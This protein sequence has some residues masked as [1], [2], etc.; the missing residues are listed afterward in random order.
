MK[1]LTFSI[2]SALLTAMSTTM[3]TSVVASVNMAAYQNNPDNSTATAT[4][5]PTQYDGQ[6]LPT[7]FATN[8]NAQLV[9]VS[10]SDNTNSQTSST[11]AQTAGQPDNMNTPAGGANQPE[12]TGTAAP[13]ANQ[14]ASTNSPATANQPATSS[15]TANSKA[16]N[17]SGQTKAPSKTAVTK[18]S[19]TDVTK[20]VSRNYERYNYLAPEYVA[21]STEKGIVYLEGEVAL[22]REFD[23]AY[24][25]ATN[26]NGVLDVKPTALEVRESNVSYEDRKINADARVS[27]YENGLVGENDDITAWPIETR[28]VNGVVYVDGTVENEEQ[29]HEVAQVLYKTEGVE[30]VRMHPELVKPY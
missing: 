21:V 13:G 8:S 18:V 23:Q 25:L 15:S 27:L 2:V 4:A 1:K 16:V 28:V 29:R 17:T 22:D 7:P 20:R 5:A 12:N 30:K 3:S 24:L 10:S 26:T 19:D 14:S 11:N 6:R 9:A